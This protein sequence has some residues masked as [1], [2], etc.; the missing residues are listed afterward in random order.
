[1]QLPSPGLISAYLLGSPSQAEDSSSIHCWMV[2]LEVMFI[3]FCMCRFP[4]YLSLEHTS[5]VSDGYIKKLNLIGSFPLHYE[6][7]VRMKMLMEG[8]KLSIIMWP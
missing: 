3:P 1:M 7:D 5:T 2:V 8:L 6:V 4:V